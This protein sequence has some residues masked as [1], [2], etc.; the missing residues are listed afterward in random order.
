MQRRKSLDLN[1]DQANLSLAEQHPQCFYHPPPHLHASL[2]PK[3]STIA[4]L[5]SYLFP[6][7]CPDKPP[8]AHF[9]LSVHKM[10]S[11][12]REE[13]ND[14]L[15]SRSSRHPQRSRPERSGCSLGPVTNPGGEFCCIKACFILDFPC[16]WFYFRV[17]RTY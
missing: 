6:G 14:L 11:G 17:W 16:P 13:R 3:H 10:S 4:S 12:P 5:P 8:R 2:P 7:S 9:C 15:P 1:L